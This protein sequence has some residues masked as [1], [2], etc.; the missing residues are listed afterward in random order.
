MSASGVQIIEGY[1]GEDQSTYH[2]SSVPPQ[3][4]SIPTPTTKDGRVEMADCSVCELD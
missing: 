3:N 4:A 1:H 2:R